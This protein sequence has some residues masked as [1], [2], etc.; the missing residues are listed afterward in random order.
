ML[1]TNFKNV[2]D[3]CKKKNTLKLNALNSQ[4][5]KKQKTKKQQKTRE[6]NVCRRCIRNEGK[7]RQPQAII[8]KIVIQTFQ[9]SIKTRCLLN[10]NSER[11]FIS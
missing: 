3:Y 7:K 11:N 9:K 10:F 2:C 4:R 8:I 5:R 6:F 1:S